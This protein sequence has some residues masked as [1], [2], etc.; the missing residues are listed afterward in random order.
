MSALT[1]RDLQRF[2]ESFL[3]PLEAAGANQTTRA[4]MARLASCLDPFQAAT[5][6]A[7]NEFLVNAQRAVEAGAWPAPGKKATTSRGGG[8]PTVADMAQKIMELYERAAA[9]ARLEFGEIDAFVD[10]LKPMTVGDLKELAKQVDVTVSSKDKKDA[11][12]LRMRDSIKSRKS[13]AERTNY[14]SERVGIGGVS[15]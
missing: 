14:G 11:I 3:V 8:K 15:S 12:L 7:F 13:R 2:L 4:E 1:V 5:L 9:D 6:T 10:S